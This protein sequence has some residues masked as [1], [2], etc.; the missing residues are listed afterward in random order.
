[1]AELIPEATALIA[2][3]LAEDVG[4][5]DWTTLWTVPEERTVVARIVAKAD[6]VLAG[7][8]IA[9]AVF[10]VGG[11]VAFV[12]ALIVIRALIRFVSQNDFV[13]FAW[14]RIA[15]GVV[16]IAWNTIWTG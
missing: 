7:V 8:E 5:G 2:A 4:A 1:M 16:L 15:L 10:A 9:E 12:S 6:G 11:V 3:A 14:Y 13:P